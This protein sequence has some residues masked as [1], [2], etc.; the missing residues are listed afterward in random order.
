M[1]FVVSLWSFIS[2]VFILQCLIGIMFQDITTLLLDHKAF[3]DTV[4]IFVDR[5]RHMAISVV[6]GTILCLS[7]S[8]SHLF[9]LLLT[10][11]LLLA[12]TFMHTYFFKLNFTCFFIFSDS[13]GENKN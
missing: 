13:V 1:C 2:G 11:I 6:A 5:Y 12:I 7:L 9:L 3:K 4:D 8:L 10:H